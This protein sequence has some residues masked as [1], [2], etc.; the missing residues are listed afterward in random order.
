[1]Y[2]GRLAKCGLPIG[3]GMV[4]GHV[5]NRMGVERRTICYRKASECQLR[6]LLG[7]MDRRESRRWQIITGQGEYNDGVCK[8]DQAEVK[9][10]RPRDGL[11]TKIQLVSVGLQLCISK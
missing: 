6:S 1:M 9:I 5:E 8:E 2:D 4:M 3:V 7:E 11:V 10:L